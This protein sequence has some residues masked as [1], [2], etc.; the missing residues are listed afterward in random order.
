MSK[1][2]VGIYLCELAGSNDQDI[3][4]VLA[5]R[6]IGVVERAGNYYLAVDDHDLVV[7][8][9]VLVVRVDRYAAFRKCPCRLVLLIFLFPSIKDDLNIYPS[10]LRLYEGVSQRR[11]GEQEHL[12]EDLPCCRFGLLYDLVCALPSRAEANL[13]GGVV[14]RQ[15]GCPGRA[16]ANGAGSDHEQAYNEDLSHSCSPI[17]TL[18]KFHEGHKALGGEPEATIYYILY[19]IYYQLIAEC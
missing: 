3:L 18:S 16:R 14:E 19:T 1:P 9:C 17:E 11:R 10:L 5:L 2:V 7:R 6:G 12:N 4:R 8:I 15:A 13:N